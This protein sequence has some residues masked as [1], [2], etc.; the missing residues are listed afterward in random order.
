MSPVGK[1]SHLK[2]QVLCSTVIT[3]RRIN[4]HSKTQKSSTLLVDSK[5]NTIIFTKGDTFEEIAELM[6]PLIKMHGFGGI[7]FDTQ[8]AFGSGYDL[9]TPEA[10]KKTFTQFDKIIGLKW[11]RMSHV[12]DSK[13]EL[14][15][16]V[17][18]HEHIGDGK[19]GKKGFEA[20]LSYFKQKKLALPLILETEH[21][22]VKADIKLMKALRDKAWK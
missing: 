10:V 1:K 15:A 18:R 3:N 7:C 5:G 13:P 8:H 9:R 21:D 12:N 16:H 14:G 11:L 22:K 20:I 4:I 2:L 19:I 17:D 6:K